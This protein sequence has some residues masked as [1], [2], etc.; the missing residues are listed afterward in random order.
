MRWRDL[1]DDDILS[2]NFDLE[3]YDQYQFAGARVF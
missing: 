3:N 2:D 1:Y